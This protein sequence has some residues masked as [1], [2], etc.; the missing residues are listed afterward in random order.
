MFSRK[1][2]YDLKINYRI[3]SQVALI[4]ILLISIG[5]VKLHLPEDKPAVQA[6]FTAEKPLLVSPPI[7]KI[8]KTPPPPSLPVVPNV[9]PDDSPLDPPPIDFGNFDDSD[10]TPLPPVPGKKEVKE[11]L[12][13]VEFMPEMQGGVQAFYNLIK[14]PESAKRNGIEGMVIVQFVV[15]KEGK[16]EDPEIIRSIGGGCD[17][18]VLRVIKLQKFTPGIQN[19]RIVK[20]RMKQTVRFRLQN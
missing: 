12:D 11:T 19:G 4:G 10:L 17:E 13:Q 2:H 9:I 15:N 20:V 6:E 3:T 8:K 16:V 14:Y 7:T 18:E 5:A 1:N